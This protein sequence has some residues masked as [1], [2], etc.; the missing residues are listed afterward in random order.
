[1]HYSAKQDKAAHRL[2]GPR[3]EASTESSMGQ[4]IKQSVREL[5]RWCHNT[6]QDQHSKANRPMLRFH[7]IESRANAGARSDSANPSK[8]HRLSITEV[9]SRPG[10]LPSAALFRFRQGFLWRCRSGEQRRVGGQD[11]HPVRRELA[12][13]GIAQH[14]FV[15]PILRARIPA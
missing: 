10:K 7:S 5:V 6:A 14:N 11:K 12:V 4:A 15:H 3:E 2:Q 13:T 1:M 8:M 9:I